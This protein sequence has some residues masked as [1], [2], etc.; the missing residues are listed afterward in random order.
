M[1]PQ[2]SHCE[3]SNSFVRSEV[4]GAVEDVRK[5][6]AVSLLSRG[7]AA[8]LGLLALPL[9]IRYLGVE[10]YGV[11]G[12]FATLQ[13]LVAFMDLGLP[14][15][16]TRQ[17]AVMSRSPEGLAQARDLAST[18]ERACMATAVLI[19][20]VLLLAAPWVASQWV[21]PQALTATQVSQALQLAAVSLAT[22]W[23]VN[24][25]SAGLAGLHRQVP[26]AIVTAVFGLLRVVVTLV[27][28]WWYPTL[29]SYF[30]AQVLVGL[31]QS[32]VMHVQMWGELALPGHRPVPLWSA[33]TQSRR[34]AGGITVI[35]VTS[36]V[37]VQA[38]KLVLSHLLELPDFGTYVVAGAL[39]G[40]LYMVIGPVF[41]VVYPRLSSMWRSESEVDRVGFY[42]A[43]S[44]ALAWMLLPLCAAMACFPE[45]SLYVL[46]AD[47]AL[48]DK[49]API[50]MA[51]LLGVACNGVMNVPYA[52][53]LAAGWTSLSVW[54]N[55][56]AAVILVPLTWWLA[57]RHGALGGA[58]AW[59][60]VHVGHFVLMPTVMHRRLLPQHNLHWYLYDVALPSAAALATALALRAMAPVMLESRPMALLQLAA[61]WAVVS[62]VTLLALPRLRVLLV[63]MIW[64]N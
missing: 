19:G 44:Q 11:V 58:I 32:A 20:L 6:L 15:T 62:A 53:Q 5:A 27:F 34:F 3:V 48:S 14:A 33:L 26:L 43:A 55:L 10:A 30:M 8:L 54:F 39:A 40:S 42:H 63:R 29:E 41:Q 45:A 24:L 59:S 38:D 1:Q 64:R 51:L 52:L 7:L 47:A 25:Y 21:R 17:L 22:G 16:L 9:Y 35:T 28:L 60:M 49:A 13:V 36:I 2:V 37:L 50:L 23:P 46:T 31:V 57:S 4:R 18:F 56:A 61:Y 12:F